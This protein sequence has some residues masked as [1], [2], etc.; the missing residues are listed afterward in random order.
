VSTEQVW[1]LR[2]EKNLVPVPKTGAGFFGRLIGNVT[3]VPTVTSGS[4]NKEK[5]ETENKKNI[6]VITV[7]NN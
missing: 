1:R 5:R 2:K 3:C 4:E 6:P 7:T